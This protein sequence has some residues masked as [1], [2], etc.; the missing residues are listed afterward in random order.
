MDSLYAQRV[1][2]IRKVLFSKYIDINIAKLTIEENIEQGNTVVLFNLLSGVEIKA[3][4]VGVVDSLFNGFKAHFKEDFPSIETLSLNKFYVKAKTATTKSVVEV[5]VE[6]VN[7]YNNF[8]SFTHSSPSLLG[9]CAIVSANLFEFFINSE[10]ACIQVYKSL[11]DAKNRARVDLITRFEA[12]LV[13][14]VKSTSYTEVIE[15]VRKEL[16]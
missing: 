11:H 2:L 9:S 5:E 4:G 8:F 1:D 13:E 12:E 14:L 10:Q 3:S 16:L 15:K 7:G 6:I